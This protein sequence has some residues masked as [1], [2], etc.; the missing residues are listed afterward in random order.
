L[1]RVCVQQ[2]PSHA[3]LKAVGTER[4]DHVAHVRQE[5]AGSDPPVRLDLL[6]DLDLCPDG[7]R[8][9]ASACNVRVCVRVWC[10]SPEYQRPGW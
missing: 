2:I 6:S 3:H 9:R 5:V 10:A 4:P 8:E 7:V 1:S